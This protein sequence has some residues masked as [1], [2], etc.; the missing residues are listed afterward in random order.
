L[1]VTLNTGTVHI[2]YGFGNVNRRIDKIIILYY[3]E[4]MR[5]GKIVWIMRKRDDI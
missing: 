4:Q 1:A 3:N 5:Y 2:E